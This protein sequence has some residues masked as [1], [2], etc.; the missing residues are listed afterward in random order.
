MPADSAAVI[1]H[2]V[3]DEVWVIRITGSLDHDNAEL[4]GE[5]LTHPDAPRT[6]V[7][8]SRTEFA[9]STF[10]HV[11]LQAQRQHD[12][13]GR[14]LVVAGPFHTIVRRLFEVTGTE[15]YFTLAEDVPSALRV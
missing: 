10:L 3:E 13:Q 12:G 4:L 14:R 15:G 6:V 1:T 9:D 8:L 5:A 7:D 11:L 2:S